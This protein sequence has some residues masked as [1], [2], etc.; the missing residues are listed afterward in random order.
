MAKTVSF[1]GS[2]FTGHWEGFKSCPYKHDSDVWTVGFGTT[3]GSG[4]HVGPNSPCISQETAHRWLRE[5]LNDLVPK[6]PKRRLMRDCE[7]DA[8]ADAGYNLGPGV[9]SDPEFST[10]A[11]RLRSVWAVSYRHRKR[12]YR[13]ELPRWNTVGGKPVAGLTARRQAEVALACNG[14]YSRRP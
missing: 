12:I 6:I 7:I 11:K 4:H 1:Q 2:R 8:L 3:S 10:L 5:T 13:E 9:L 14:D